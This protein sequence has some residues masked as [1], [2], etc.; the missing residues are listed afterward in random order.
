MPT[1]DETIAFI[2]KAH[3]GQ[4]D[5]SGAPYWH[6]P[7]AVMEILQGMHPDAT[8]DELHAALLHDVIEDTKFTAHDLRDLGYSDRTIALVSGLSRPTGDTRPSYMDWIRSIAGTG[9]RDLIRIKL[10][11]NMH[12]SHPDRIAQLPP[13]QRDIVNRYRRSMAILRAALGGSMA[14]LRRICK[15][16]GGMKF[17]GADGK[18]VEWVWDYVRDEP[19]L[20]SDMDKEA[21]AASERRKYEKLRAEA[22]KKNQG[23]LF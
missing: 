23:D 17:K 19:R 3:A 14:G 15:L 9:D 6:H 18:T 21:R 8:E 4:T 22:D 13:E 7:V 5:K 12:N 2:Q 20:K 16:Y 11:D 10:A 1:L